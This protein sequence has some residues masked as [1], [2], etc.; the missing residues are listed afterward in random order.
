V[1]KERFENGEDIGDKIN[2][3]RGLV[4]EL[5]FKDGLK[6]IPILDYFKLLERV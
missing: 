3:L 5:N 4:T 6:E 2:I 1:Y